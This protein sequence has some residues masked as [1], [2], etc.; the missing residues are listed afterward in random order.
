VPGMAKSAGTLIAMAADD[1]LMGSMS[2]L[3]PIDAQ[4]M[5]Q[6]KQFSAHALLEGMEKIKKEVLATGTLNRAYVPLLQNL[7]PGE[8]QHAEHALDFASELVTE[9]LNTYKFKNWTTH[10]SD[11]RPVT[12]EDRRQRAKDIAAI[13]RDQTRWKTHGRSL[14]ID[15]LRAMRLMVTDYTETADLCDA[16]RR[17][18]TLLQMTFETNVYKIFETPSSQIYRLEVPQ[19]R[20]LFGGPG[21]QFPVLPPGTKPGSIEAGVKCGKCGTN[22]VVQVKLDPRA[23]DRPGAIPLP[24]DNLVRCPGPKCNEV[25]DLTA[26]RQQA[27]RASGAQG[28]NA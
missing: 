11:G 22:F 20:D 18:Y 26:F 13:L 12:P 24:N 10:S 16:I 27:L 1:L 2:S 25:H 5:W 6:G 15:D 8:L 23:K 9:W 28:A 4:I 3:G 17:Y 7:S 21:Q 14:K 19:A